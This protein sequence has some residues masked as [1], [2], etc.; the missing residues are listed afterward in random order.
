[1][2]ALFVSFLIYCERVFVHRRGIAIIYEQSA[3]TTVIGIVAHTTLVFYTLVGWIS[4]YVLWRNEK[5]RNNL[6][7]L[8]IVYLSL[9][10]FLFISALTLYA[11]LSYVGAILSNTTM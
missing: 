4:L 10:H 7:L 8:A 6:P 3:V 1:M 2:H 11:L 5:L 9:I